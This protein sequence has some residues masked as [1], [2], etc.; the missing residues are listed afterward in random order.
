MVDPDRGQSLTAE[1][2]DG[3]DGFVIANC[4]EIPGCA[5]QGATRVEALANL[6]DAIERLSGDDARGLAKERLSDI[7]EHDDGVRLRSGTDGSCASEST[8][9]IGRVGSRSR[10]FR[11]LGRQHVKTLEAL[12]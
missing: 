12:A 11:L 4:L 7:R 3:A 5:S 8:P 2:A 10:I 6:A 1:I 9:E